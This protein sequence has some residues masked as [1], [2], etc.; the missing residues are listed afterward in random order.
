MV[1]DRKSCVTVRDD[2]I[3]NFDSNS[4]I[5]YDSIW[6]SSSIICACIGI[7]MHYENR[8]VPGVSS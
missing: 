1:I 5:I 6:E 7:R 4:S 8:E 3:V 2:M